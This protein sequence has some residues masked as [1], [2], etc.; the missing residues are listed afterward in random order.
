M[1]KKVVFDFD[2]TLI[3]VN[4]FPKWVKFLAWSKF[5]NLD[6]SSFSKIIG[7]IFKRKLLNS[8]RHEEFKKALME[9]PFSADEV[10]EFARFLKSFEHQN[11]MGKLQQLLDEGCFVAIS[12]AAPEMYLKV[13]AKI[14][15]LENVTVIGASISENKLILNHS[16]NKIENLEEKGFIKPTEKIEVLFTDSEEDWP[17]AQRSHKTIL[18]N[19]SENTLS[20]YRNQNRTIVEI[21]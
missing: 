19:P 14:T 1:D 13:Y 7:L 17:L 9:L 2:G 16:I 20:F 12:S 10:I 11:V 3:R 8:I 4:S 15:E 6:F 5:K 21:L 18:V